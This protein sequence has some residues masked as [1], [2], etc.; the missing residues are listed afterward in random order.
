MDDESTKQVRELSEAIQMIGEA[1]GKMTIPDESRFLAHKLVT[2]FG[3]I[4][5]PGNGDTK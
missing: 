4:D 1:F 2:H 3:H 5:L